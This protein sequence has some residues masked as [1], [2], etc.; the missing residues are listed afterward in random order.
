MGTP[1]SSDRVP[2][3]FLPWEAGANHGLVGWAALPGPNTIQDSLNQSPHLRFK[4]ER[5]LHKESLAISSSR[6]RSE[7][8]R[9]YQVW[10]A[11]FPRVPGICMAPW[12]RY[13]P[14][15]VTDVPVN[16]SIISITR[17]PSHHV[18]PHP[19]HWGHI[20]KIKYVQGVTKNCGPCLMGHRG[21]NYLKD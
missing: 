14:I 12:S 15:R 16:I 21:Q 7:C 1:L 5:E 6:S 13:I 19:Q 2:E 20:W 11:C 3:T 18:N 9:V 8:I 4:R 10:M 17:P